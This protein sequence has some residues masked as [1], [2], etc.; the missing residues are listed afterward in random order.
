ML[1][2][3]ILFFL[4]LFCCLNSLIVNKI[5]LKGC[6][7]LNQTKILKELNL[8]KNIELKD[9]ESIAKKIVNIY[10]NH[11]YYRVVVNHPIA[12]PI[13]NNLINLEIEIIE[14]K[15]YELKKVEFEGN[16]YF[17]S[18]KL[19]S[20]IDIDKDLAN[21]EAILKQI[22]DLYV[23]RGFLFAKASLKTA[24]L[25]K[26]KAV[27]VITI[28][29][30]KPFKFKNTI[31]KGNKI[32]K[33]KSIIKISG[34]NFIE[35]PKLNDFENAS[36]NLL[37][38]SYI[39]NCVIA[40][41]NE[42]TLLI[43]IDEGPMTYFSALGAFDN[44]KKES[45]LSGK[46]EIEFLNISGT[47]RS[48]RLYW[49]NLSKNR[50]ELEL[51]YHEP[52]FDKINI[53]ADF[54]FNRIEADSTYIK[55]SFDVDLYYYMLNQKFGVS[56]GY[57]SINPG[58]RRPIIYEKHSRKKIG[59]F[60]ELD[61]TDFYLNPSSGI[62]LKA[63][64][65]NTFDDSININSTEIEIKK[66]F[67]FDQEQNWVLA[68]LNKLNFKQNKDLKIYDYYNLGGSN[69]LRGF[70]QDLFS[71][72]IT[73]LSSVELRYLSSAYSRLFIFAD[74]GFVEFEENNKTKK[75]TDLLALGFGLRIKTRLGMLGIDY[76]IG[77][78]SGKWQNP[79]DGIVH[80]GIETSF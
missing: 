79:M 67:K 20:L 19:K 27:A 9:F 62:K 76:G 18:K 45:E 71:G 78:I 66:Y 7:K 28:D 42:E 69:N 31:V 55:T 37:K 34:L 43:D 48:F 39:K 50:K 8:N 47:D 4:L 57:E 22:V 61:T 25:V 35:N 80:F 11:G 74:Y 51:N 1:K 17:S 44:S 6:K 52:G 16:F 68:S 70:S 77:H 59:F 64:Y 63:K 40:P 73:M 30:G 23:S 36:K 29:E 65:Y 26:N 46:A 2:N 5:T 33:E 60:Y 15:N 38:K 14:N 21:I 72:Y 75:L 12:V 56:L 10:K 41:I 3:L 13:S 32:S 24:K 53:A 54:Y 58:K 49:E